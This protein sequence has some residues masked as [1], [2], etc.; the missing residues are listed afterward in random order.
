MEGSTSI[1]QESL[2][3]WSYDFP[4]EAILENMGK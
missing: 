2:A 4:S 3:S 1:I